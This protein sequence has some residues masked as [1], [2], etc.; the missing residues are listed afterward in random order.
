M[1]RREVSYLCLERER[2]GKQERDETEN[3]KTFVFS[4]KSSL[5]RDVQLEPV[6][7]K[8]SAEK[9]IEQVKQCRE[10]RSLEVKHQLLLGEGVESERQEEEEQEKEEEE[11]EEEEEDKGCHRGD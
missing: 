6:K 5:F 1:N 3:I 7:Y 8:E 2:E 4:R 11:E 10:K 9:K